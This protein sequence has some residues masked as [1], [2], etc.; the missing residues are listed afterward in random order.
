MLVKSGNSVENDMDPCV[1]VAHTLSEQ[2]TDGR[3]S[4][5]KRNAATNAVEDS[6]RDDA[7]ICRSGS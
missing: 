6:T 7:S 3:S 1:T 5:T 2:I 4:Y